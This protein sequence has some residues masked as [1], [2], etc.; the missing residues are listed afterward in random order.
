MS[1]QENKEQ[2]DIGDAEIKADP[3]LVEKAQ[4]EKEQ[5]EK[6]KAIKKEESTLFADPTLFYTDEKEPARKNLPLKIIIAL[7]AVAVVIGAAFAIKA[8]LPEKEPADTSSKTSISIDITKYASDDV[9]KMTVEGKDYTTVLYSMLDTSSAES[10]TV[11]WGIEGIDTSLTDSF[12]IS[13][14]VNSAVTLSALREMEKLEADYGFDEPNAKITVQSRNQKFETYTITVGKV[15]ADRSGYYLKTSL[16]DKVY[17]VKKE[18]VEAFCKDIYAFANTTVISALTDGDAPA[19]YFNE[20]TLI[21][22]DNI[23]IKDSYYGEYDLWFELNPDQNTAPFMTYVMTKPYRR[24]A[25]NE[26]VK[27]LITPLSNGVYAERVYSYD[28]T[29]EELEKYGLVNPQILITLKVGNVTHTL[30]AALN[31]DG[32][33]ATMLDDNKTIYQVGKSTIEVVTGHAINYVSKAIF[34]EMLKNFTDIDVTVDNKTYDFNINVVESEEEDVYNVTA[35]TLPLEAE[36]FQN[37]YAQLLGMTVTEVSVKT[38]DNI[39]PSM[40]VRLT[41]KNGSRATI[42]FA[43]TADRRYHVSV[44]GEPGGYI[45]TTTYEKLVNYTASVYEGKEIP[46]VTMQ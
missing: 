6:T 4:A 9:E 7:A 43:Q 42:E 20:G 30:K 26:M 13:Q 1:E 33:Y 45:S 12:S 19:E 10:T 44:D 3:I 32:Y 29:Q 34:T 37:Y 16:A 17:L 24:L 22:V 5:A 25:D 14:T 8:L 31:N 15:A 40:T 36:N 38:P 41:R 23:Y 46:K 21:K 2:I 39:T 35:G 28:A 11:K 18:T 27:N